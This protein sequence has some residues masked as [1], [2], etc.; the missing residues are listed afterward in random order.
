MENIKVTNSSTCR[1]F[2][3]YASRQAIN[4]DNGVDASFKISFISE[5]EGAV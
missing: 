5:H 3:F 2:E 4:C 1:Q